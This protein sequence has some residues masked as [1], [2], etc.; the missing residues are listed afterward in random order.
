MSANTVEQ[1]VIGLVE[2]FTDDWG[3]DLEVTTQTML[4][5]DIGF[6]SSDTMQLFAAIQ[7]YYNSV[8]FKFQDLVMEDGK[9][10]DD[11]KLGQVIVFVIRKLAVEAKS[12]A[13]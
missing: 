4:K 13:M 8:D 11:L 6:N 5:G 12:L 1:V 9:Y 7:E 2:D 10:K 3:I